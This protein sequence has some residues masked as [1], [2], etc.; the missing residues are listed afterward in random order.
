[1]LADGN[2]HPLYAV[3]D[4]INAQLSTITTFSR[5]PVWDSATLNFEVAANDRLS[6]TK[7][8]S[9]LDA[10]SDQASVAVRGTFEPTYFAVLPGLD[11][12]P[13]LGAG[14]NFLGNAS[15]GYSQG[16]GAG[17]LEVGL[18]ATYR[19]VWSANFTFS[20]FIGSDRKQPLADRDF[21]SFSIQ[22]TF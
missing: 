18:T 21:I 15:A 20:H 7:N 16:K 6:V 9:A 10:S 2:K 8:L 13:I 19:V 1:V 22:R 4:T 14:F 3:G 17:D 5:S 12:T 11:L